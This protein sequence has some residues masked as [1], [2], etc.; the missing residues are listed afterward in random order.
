MRKTCFITVL[1]FFFGFKI[2][3]LIQN[4]KQTEK[5]NN[6]LYTEKFKKIKTN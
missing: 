5:K 2:L 3:N 1:Q 4:L 6:I